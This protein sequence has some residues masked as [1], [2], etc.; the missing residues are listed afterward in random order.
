GEAPVLGCLPSRRKEKVMWNHCV[1]YYGY[2]PAIQTLL[3]HESMERKSGGDDNGGGG[4]TAL[5]TA[6]PAVTSSRMGLSHSP[7]GVTAITSA[8]GRAGRVHPNPHAKE[9]DGAREYRVGSQH[10]GIDASPPAAIR[11]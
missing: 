8:N 11:E 10:Q 4:I 3:H 2:S 5:L 7:Q 9:G 6:P 1:R